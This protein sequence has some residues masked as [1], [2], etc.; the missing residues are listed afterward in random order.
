MCI[1]PITRVS[2]VHDQAGVHQDHAHGGDGPWEYQSGGNGNARGGEVHR[3]HTDGQDEGNRGGLHH[4]IV[5]GRQDDRK[6][7]PNER[8]NQRPRRKATPKRKI[9]EIEPG[10][11]QEKITSFLRLFPNLDGKGT[12]TK[13]KTKISDLKSTPSRKRKVGLDPEGGISPAKRR[14]K[15]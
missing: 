1:F 9:Q 3:H 4:V 14:C 12:K 13:M 6:Q 5:V 2:G 8:L 11:V 15:E 10:L 7:T